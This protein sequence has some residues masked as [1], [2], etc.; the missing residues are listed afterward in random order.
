VQN[1]WCFSGNLKITTKVIFVKHSFKAIS[2][3]I[4][5]VLG[6]IPGKIVINK[7]RVE[8]LPEICQTGKKRRHKS[9]AIS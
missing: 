1:Q 9:T 4:M 2:C 3:H 6:G 8:F 5:Q 7:N